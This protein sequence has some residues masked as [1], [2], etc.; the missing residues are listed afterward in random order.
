MSRNQILWSC[1]GLLVTLSAAAGSAEYPLNPVRAELFKDDASLI[2]VTFQ[3]QPADRPAITSP[4]ETYR[5][6]GAH[7]ETTWRDTATAKL[8]ERYQLKP[9][10]HWPITSLGVHCVVFQVGGGQ[11]IN[12]VMERMRKDELVDSVQPMNRFFA[13]VVP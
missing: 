1:L 7:Y 2:L 12:S 11:D 8:A 6:R 5:Q 4:A 9:T 13:T 3:D 10:Q